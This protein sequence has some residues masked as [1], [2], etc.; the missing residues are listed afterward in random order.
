MTCSGSNLQCKLSIHASSAFSG[1]TRRYGVYRYLFFM[2]QANFVK[3]TW[4]HAVSMLVLALTP[5]CFQK[6]TAWQVHASISYIKC[7][8]LWIYVCFYGCRGQAII[9]LPCGFFYLLS[10]SSFF[11][12][13]RLISAVA[14]RMSTI[15]LHIVW[16]ECEFRMQ[17]WNVLHAA[18]WK[19]RM[20]KWRKNRH[21]GTFSQL[22]RALSLQIRY[23]STVGKNLLNID[24]S[25]L[26]MSSWWTSAY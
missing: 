17:V 5:F 8:V 20:Q 7:A 14:Q 2:L 12:F 23:L 19:Y 3:I 16:P 4:G 15:L 6:S 18:R 24:I 10:S 11:S 26:H 13:P 25:L 9:F 22:C 21:F 1:S